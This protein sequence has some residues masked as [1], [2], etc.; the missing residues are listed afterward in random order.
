MK[1]YERFADK[2][3]HTSIASTFGIDF[4]AF[5]SIVLPRL[6]GAGCRN[7]VLLP[8]SSM[9]THALNGASALPQHAGRLYS[10]RGSGAAGVFHP[11]VFLQ[12]GR[13][14]GRLIVSSA[15][16]TTPGLGRQS[17]TRRTRRLRRSGLGRAASDRSGME[18]SIGSHRRSRPRRGHSDRM[19]ARACAVAPARRP[20]NWRR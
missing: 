11:K 20:G 16:M 6:R 2:D 3:F 14:R 8:D 19:D 18:L 10:V 1:L 12:V 13:R 5:E 9:L 7:N 17:R 15:N 4:E